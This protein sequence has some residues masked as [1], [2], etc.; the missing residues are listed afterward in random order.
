MPLL[1]SEMLPLNMEVLLE[2][3]EELELQQGLE[4]VK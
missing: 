4:G 2:K 3:A 1:H